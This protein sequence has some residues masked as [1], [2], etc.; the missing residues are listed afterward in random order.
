MVIAIPANF[1]SS[2]SSACTQVFGNRTVPVAA[3][4]AT[5]GLQEVQKNMLN[6]VTVLSVG[7]L[8]VFLPVEVVVLLT[9]LIVAWPM[10]RLVKLSHQLGARE[11]MTTKDAWRSLIGEQQAP[12]VAGGGAT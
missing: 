10:L 9:P 5:F 3:Q 6:T 2:I 11:P 12:A 4:G 8:S 1:G 7:V